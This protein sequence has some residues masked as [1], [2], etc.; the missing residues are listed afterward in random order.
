MYIHATDVHKIKYEQIS[1]SYV[2]LLWM[3]II[4][5]G[6]IVG[7]GMFLSILSK[8]Q[9]EAAF[10]VYKLFEVLIVLQDYLYFFPI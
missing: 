5:S 3:P 1:T 8:P 7:V 2:V 6:I 10:L 9:S 4:F